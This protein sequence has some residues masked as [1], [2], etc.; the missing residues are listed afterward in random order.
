MSSASRH[1]AP[2]GRRPRGGPDP[3]TRRVRSVSD[4]DPGER[5]LKVQVIGDRAVGVPVR[6]L[7]TH[8]YSLPSYSG[9]ATASA[10]PADERP[11]S[12]SPP[13][14][15]TATATTS[16]ATRRPC[17]TPSTAGSLSARWPSPTGCAPSRETSEPAV[18]P[19][20]SG[21]DAPDATTSAPACP[22]C[23]TGTPTSTTCSATG[24]VSLRPMTL[25]PVT[26]PPVT[27]PPVTS[28]TG[29][30]PKRCPPR[31]RSGASAPSSAGSLPAV[32]TSTRRTLSASTG[33]SRLS[34]PIVRLRSPCPTRAV[35]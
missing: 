20:R 26:L 5:T 2:P 4:R 28:T 11:S 33:P 8:P 18:W 7:P 23:P 32:R 35:S 1:T 10:S 31:K 3:T 22:T 30:V 19:V 9:A 6:L 25:P 12:E 16:G 15:S 24:S 29:C 27:L 13:S 17:S 14:P 21:S 34:G